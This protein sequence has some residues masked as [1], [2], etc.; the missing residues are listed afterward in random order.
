MHHA[1]EKNVRPTAKVKCAH[2]LGTRLCSAINLVSVNVLSLMIISHFTPRLTLP[3]SVACNMDSRPLEGET[4][5]EVAK[6]DTFSWG[7]GEAT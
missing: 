5:K 4:G 1:H 2:G 6:E 7:G 3:V